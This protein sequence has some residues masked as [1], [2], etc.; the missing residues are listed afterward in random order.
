MMELIDLTGNWRY[1]TRTG[2]EKVAC[3]L[4]GKLV[5]GLRQ[6]R[7]A[8]HGSWRKKVAALL[9]LRSTERSSNT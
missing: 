5:G 8:V 1:R 3:E 7:K 9:H 6:H 2:S 4:C